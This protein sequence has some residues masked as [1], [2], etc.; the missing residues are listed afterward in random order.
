MGQGCHT[1]R[2]INNPVHPAMS[3]YGPTFITQCVKLCTKFECNQ[4]IRGDCDFSIC[5]N[6]LKY[7]SRII[8]QY[9]LW[10]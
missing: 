2:S 6:N 7:V 8:W 4:A 5:P 1:L 9:Y 3:Q 10:K